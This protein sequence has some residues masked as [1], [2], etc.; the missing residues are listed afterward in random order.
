MM[1]YKV[2]EKCRVC[3]STE[4]RKY[5]DLGSHPLANALLQSKDSLIKN[6][7]V[8]VFFCEECSLSQLSVVVDPAVM[9]SDYPYHSSVSQ[10]FKAH[11]RE[12]ARSVKKTLNLNAIPEAKDS[13]PFVVD[14]ASNDGCLLN[15]FQEEGF[16][17]MGVEPCKALAD[18]AERRGIS[19]INEFWPTNGFNACDVITATNVFAHVDDVKNFARVAGRRLREFSKGLMVIEVPYLR[20]L[21]EQN[22]FD[23]IYHEH[24]S[25]FL[26]KPLVVL[27]ASINMNV[28]KVEE[29]PIH[30]GS[31]RIYASP[32]D[33]EADGSVLRM[34]I[35]EHQ[36]GL[37]DYSTYENYS[38]NV[39]RIK[40]D[41]SKVLNDCRERGETVAGF[42]ASAKGISLMNYCGITNTD[43]SYIADDTPDKQ[44]KF[45][46]GSSIPIVSRD[47][48]DTT[49]PEYIVI[50]AWNFAKEMK[51]KTADVGAKY[52]VPIPKVSVE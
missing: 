16:Y 47:N 51:A 35:A 50:M 6:Y 27:F 34:L 11:C 44:G 20:N 3:E 28:F 40:M 32:Y 41:L 2:V 37:Y 24:L 14:I 4:L 23:T 8:Q 25:Y 18:E 39:Q 21:I 9:Y 36:A 10:T 15:E 43:I 45:T 1:D 22:Q 19:T 33:R 31:L 17:V 42:G 12:M 49:H 30:G 26:L 13:K 5:L 29:V 48:F 46:P 38:D 7:P 52:I